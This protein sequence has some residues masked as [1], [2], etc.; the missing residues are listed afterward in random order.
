[1]IRQHARM[2]AIH[3]LCRWKSE[4]LLVDKVPAPFGSQETTLLVVAMIIRQLARSSYSSLATR[5]DDVPNNT[6]IVQISNMD[7]TEQNKAVL[8]SCRYLPARCDCFVSHF[9]CQLRSPQLVGILVDRPAWSGTDDDFHK[10]D[11]FNRR[12]YKQSL[13]CTRFTYGDQINNMDQ[14]NYPELKHD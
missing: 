6:I 2:S 9:F 12:R 4:H 8:L 1:M 13:S 7:S 14:S 11:I 5:S 10:S 3:S